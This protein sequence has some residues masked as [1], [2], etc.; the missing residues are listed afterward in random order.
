MYSSLF[1]TPVPRFGLPWMVLG[2]QVPPNGPG[3]RVLIQPLRNRF[4]RDSCDVL[5][6][7]AFHDGSFPWLDCSFA[8]REGSTGQRFH[9][10]VAVTQPAASLTA[11]HA[12]TQSTMRFLGQI[13]QEQRIH[14][15]FE[16]DV[17]MRDVAFGERDDAYA[18]K[19]EALEETSGVFLVTAEAVQRFS[20]HDVESA[21]QGIA[22]QRLET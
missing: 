8:S 12:P 6:E 20:E 9:H 7:D 15:P 19:G 5:P 4:R 11:L 17:Q 22:H 21:V 16:P 10:A 1:R 18:G 13:L 3:D 14:R 2:L